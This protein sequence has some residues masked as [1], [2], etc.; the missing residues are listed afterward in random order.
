MIRDNTN[1]KEMYVLPAL[2]F[3]VKKPS[4]IQKGIKMNIEYQTINDNSWKGKMNI[5]MNSLIFPIDLTLI[6]SFYDLEISNTV[7]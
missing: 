6:R 3:K 5:N 2:A 1:N 4:K 7:L